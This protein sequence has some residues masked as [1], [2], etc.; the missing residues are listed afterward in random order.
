VVG[1]DHTEHDRTVL[2]F[3]FDEA[4]LRGVPV[5][6]VYVWWFADD[7]GEQR[8]EYDEAVLDAAAARLVA[9]ATAD[10]ERRYPGVP[11]KHRP[12]RDTNPSAVLIEQSAHAGLVVVG[13]RGRGGFASLLLGS[14]GRDLIGHADAPVTVIH[15]HA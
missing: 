12:I 11:V 10:V 9:E 5:I 6:C 1:I 4:A 15:D 8:D 14:V 13:C 2:A 7:V 3:A